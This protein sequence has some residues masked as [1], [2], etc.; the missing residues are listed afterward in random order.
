MQEIL[1]K[2]YKITVLHL[3]KI[4][5]NSTN[6]NGGC[7]YGKKKKKDLQLLAL[8]AQIAKQL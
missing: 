5:D 8:V 2:I 1:V 7:I 4:K 6:N 3:R